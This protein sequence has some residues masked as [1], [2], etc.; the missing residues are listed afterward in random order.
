M[1]SFVI[2]G[3]V[4][5]LLVLSGCSSKEPVVEES[6]Q[7][8]QEVSVEKV[9][10]VETETVSSS[11]ASVMSEDTSNASSSSSGSMSSIED[12]MSTIYFD[13][14]KFNIRADMENRIVNDAGVANGAASS[15]SLKL[16]GNCDEWGSDEYNFALGLRRANT[17]KKSL[18]AEG[19]DANR[20]TM[21]SYGE[22]NPTCSIK[23]ENC[24]SKNRRV[25]FKLLP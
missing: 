14:D 3:V 24:W 2:S 11:E 7:S 9:A 15:F 22:S 19:V 18:I 20:I 17:V 6:V 16:E 23:S 13:F 21:V 8:P 25:D 4:A 5:A 10:P 1:N 12:G